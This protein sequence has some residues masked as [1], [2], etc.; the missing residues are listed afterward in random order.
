MLL[1]DLLYKGSDPPKS[2]LSL[3]HVH[4][5]YLP[6]LP[7]F[8]LQAP[9]SL[10]LLVGPLKVIFQTLVVLHALLVR[11]PYTTEFIIVQVSYNFSFVMGISFIE[12]HNS[13]A[14]T[15]A[16]TNLYL[17]IIRIPLPYPHWR[18]SISST[19]HKSQNSSSTGTILDTAFWPFA[20]V[21]TTDWSK[22]QNGEI[23]ILAQN[24]EII[25]QYKLGLREH[26]AAL[27]T[28]ICL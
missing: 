20:W 21:T 10:F 14:S 8:I 12:F 28:H 2:L 26:S 5:L 13:P 18:S 11:L 7:Q 4:F 25:A 17:F 23:E 19:G 6:T 3:P 27:R 15:P 9:R 1:L 24:R 16:L 22:L